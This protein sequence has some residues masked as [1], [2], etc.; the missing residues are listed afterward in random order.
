LFTTGKNG[1]AVQQIIVVRPCTA[2]TSLPCAASS[3]HGK[4]ISHGN[5][6]MHGKVRRQRTAKKCRR[7]RPNTPHGK[8]ILHGKGSGRCRGT[9]FDVR[10]D[11]LHDNVVF[12]VRSFLC[13]A[14]T[15]ILFVFIFILFHLILI[16]IF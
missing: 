15:Y 1:I 9:P 5:E 11:R 16:F 6:T 12:A 8:E 4:E 14:P 13:R 7:Q 3:T 2:K 10:A